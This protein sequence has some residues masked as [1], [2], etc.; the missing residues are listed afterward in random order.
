VSSLIIMDPRNS[1]DSFLSSLAPTSAAKYKVRIQQFEL[2]C[3]INELE[4][5]PQ[6]VQVFIVELHEKYMAST[7][8]NIFSM[9]K[10]Y[11][12]HL[13]Q[14]DLALLLPGV[15]RLLKQWEKSESKTQSKV[16]CSCFVN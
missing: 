4:I 10:S 6:S 3:S 15:P 12:L 16:I 2:F 8:W 1:L 5:I 14:L 9:L 7:L 11:F 13:Y